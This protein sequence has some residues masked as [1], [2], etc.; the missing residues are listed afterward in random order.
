MWT[1]QVL[2]QHCDYVSDRNDTETSVETQGRFQTPALLPVSLPWSRSPA[3]PCLYSYISKIGENKKSVAFFGCGGR[4]GVGER[5]CMCT[6]LVFG[7]VHTHRDQRLT[8]NGYLPRASLPYF[9]WNNGF[10][11]SLEPINSASLANK[12]EGFSGFHLPAL[13]LKVPCRVAFTWVLGIWTWV[14]VFVQQIL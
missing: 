3:S 10:F 11:L 14:H 5:E 2:C 8:D 13:K 6:C 9:F 12:P 1:T 7:H 4:G